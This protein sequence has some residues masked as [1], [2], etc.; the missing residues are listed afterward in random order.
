MARLLVR[1][2][3]SYEP[4]RRYA[5]DVVLGTI[6]GLEYRA[7]PHDEAW[8]EIRLADETEGK[9]LL[10]TDGLFTTPGH[11][12]LTPQSMPREPLHRWQVAQDLPEVAELVPNA[13]V[14]Y[15]TAR[16]AAWLVGDERE[17]ELRLDVFGGAFFMLTR[18]EELVVPERDAHGRFPARASLA[19]RE[20][21]LLRP[22]VDEYARILLACL[23]RL[24]PGL[25]TRARTP[26][27]IV[28]HD[29]DWPLV[30]QGGLGATLRAA[31]ADVLRRRAPA[32]A[33]NRVRAYRG[34]RRGDHRFDPHNTFDF[35][36]DACEEQGLRSAFYFIAG[37]TAG[38][39]DGEY[40]LDDP[41]ISSLMRRIHDRGHEIGLHASYA[42]HD[43]P[44]AIARE[45][46]SLMDAARRLGVEQAEWGG[47][48]HF[49]RWQAP[50]TWRAWEAAG[51]AYDSTVGFA[52]HV[53]F[54]SGTCCEH[55]VFDV[56][57]RR[58]LALRERPLV[59]MEAS[60]LRKDHMG[61]DHCSALQ[62]ALELRS[63][64]EAFGG[65][66]TLLW[67]NSQLLTAADRRVFLTLID[68]GGR[69]GRTR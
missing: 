53:G 4:E 20:G 56:E 9:R 23:R 55:R 25:E 65:D 39:I 57:E 21:L 6:L 2:P 38:R 1:Y 67:H 51:L 3:P 54:R 58:T 52:D 42:S 50:L 22:I 26:R 36:M 37:H 27:L 47:R 68:S 61:L 48:Q 69:G 5:I 49:L 11:A 66:F 31:A 7:E 63:R 17:L 59:V 16:G 28:T 12:W 13:P 40:T 43:D 34:R 10:V 60:L 33:V 19:W 46:G 29:V 18:Y 45:F 41:W 35:L 15:G 14:L 64:C 62:A 24:W 32:V 8:T 44:G 30:P